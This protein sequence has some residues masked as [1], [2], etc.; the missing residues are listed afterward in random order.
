MALQYSLRAPLG[1]K[2]IVTFNDMSPLK[3]SLCW[4]PLALQ[5]KEP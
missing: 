4:M 3:S 1:A 2:G 5:G